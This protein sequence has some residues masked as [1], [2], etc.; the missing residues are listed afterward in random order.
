MAATVPSS[1]F[2]LSR[3]TTSLTSQVS[4]PFVGLLELKA[5]LLTLV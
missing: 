5:F 1:L 4:E 2:S 3:K